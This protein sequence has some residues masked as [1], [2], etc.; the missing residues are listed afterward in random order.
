MDSAYFRMLIHEL[1]NK[2]PDISTDKDPFIMLD[3][4]YSVFMSKNGK[5]AKHTSHI[6]IRVYFVRYG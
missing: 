6:A 2:D 1:L 4:N 3:R 5:D